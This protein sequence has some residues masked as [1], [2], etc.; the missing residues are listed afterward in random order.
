[1]AAIAG[2][3]PDEAR[4]PKTPTEEEMTATYPKGK[5]GE[6]RAVGLSARVT[7]SK[8]SGSKPSR[9]AAAG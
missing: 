6:E 4:E 9:G 1:M 8:A 7:G 3:L 2:L 5:A